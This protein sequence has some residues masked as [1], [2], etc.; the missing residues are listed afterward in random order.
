MN[1]NEAIELLLN[2]GIT[3]K[4]TYRKVDKIIN[5]NLHLIINKKKIIS[6]LDKVRYDI[7]YNTS[8]W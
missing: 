1:I 5:D 6:K 3:D 2:D 8:K 4:R 7:F